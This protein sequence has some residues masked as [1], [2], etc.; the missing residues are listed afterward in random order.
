MYHKTT[1]VS[2]DFN[3]IM[4]S[5]IVPVIFQL[6]LIE[7][8]IDELIHG[9]HIKQSK[10]AVDEATSSDNAS[11]TSLLATKRPLGPDD[12]CPICQE[13]LLASTRALTHCRWA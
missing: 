4:F 7:R 11:S 1:P 5:L 12:V 13:D 10:K 9:Y 6:A 3:T 8:E 2:N